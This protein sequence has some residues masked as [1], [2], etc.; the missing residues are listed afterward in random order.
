[1]I[2]EFFGP[3]PGKQNRLNSVKNLVK[4]EGEGPCSFH[5]FY[6]KRW[7]AMIEETRV[8][9]RKRKG[10]SVSARQRRKKKERAEKEANTKKEHAP[11]HLYDKTRYENER[12]EIP[13][14]VRNIPPEEDRHESYFF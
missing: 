1:M 4:L 13:V 5:E 7:H 10:E 11:F 2:K 3:W 6:Y 12:Y 9:R 14:R 8:E